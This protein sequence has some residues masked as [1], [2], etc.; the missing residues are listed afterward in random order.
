VWQAGMTLAA[1]TLKY[2]YCGALPFAG[3]SG[4][5]PWKSFKDS[6][7]KF[8]WVFEKES[9]M[10]RFKL[11]PHGALVVAAGALVAALAMYFWMKHEQ[12]ATAQELPFAARIQ[13]VDGEVAFSDNRT[14]A[15]ANQ[16]WTAATANQP[17]SEGDRIYTRDN[18][19][20]S[21]AFNGRNFARL[22]PNTSLDCL[23]LRDRRTQLALRDG[24][25]MFDV[26]YLQPDEIFEVAT[27]NGSVNFVQPGLYNVGFDQNGGV[28]VSVLS[29]LAQVA[30][31][32]GSGQVNKGEMLTLLGQ[33]ASQIALSRLNGQDAGRQVDDYYRYQYPN[34]YD[35]RY[36]NYDAYLN[37][38]N[39]YDPSRR[40]VSYQYASSYIPGLNDLDSYGDW[41]NVSGYGNVWR[42][43][44]SNGWVPYQDGQWVNNYPYGPTWVSN[45][46]W[47]YAPY[48]YGRWANVGNQWY[49]IPDSAN[50]TPQ[51]APALVAFV[52]LND[53]N[54]IGWVPLGPGDNY[55]P[56]YYDENWQPR[57]LQGNVA[58]ARLVNLG[59]PGAVTVVP[60]DAFGRAIDPRNVRRID[61]ARLASTS[62]TLDPLTYTPLRNAFVNSAPSAF[63]RGKINL[64]PGI[65]KKLNDTRVY[66]G[67]DITDSRFRKDFAR[68]MRVER[69]SDQARNQKFKVKDER[70]E[71]QADNGRRQDL[72]QDLG[73]VSAE[74]VKD[75]KAGKENKDVQRQ[76]RQLEQQQQKDVRVAERA[77]AQ[78][79]RQTR[80]V[81]QQQ[82]RQARV[83][84]RAQAQTQRHAQQEQKRQAAPAERARVQAQPAQVQ[85]QRQSQPR[86]EQRPQPQRPEAQRVAQPARPA[87]S[88]ARP[89][90]QAAPKQERKQKPLDAKPGG[91]GNGGG[92][93]KGKG[94]KP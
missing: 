1:L 27:P 88:E 31:L 46:S 92:G 12:T 52:P 63:G 41:Q 84:E 57:Y 24:S 86:M 5:R 43:R 48:H 15:Q 29:G 72:R 17:F 87:R 68:S 49:W 3:L 73:R 81:E 45:E 14:G 16:D 22:N 66:A 67:N 93:G 47:G 59:I 55:A 51:Y 70:G 25:A 64:P 36:N 37:E 40:N 54:Q 79:Q 60:V 76:T 58:P 18:A 61:Q 56:R 65:A 6:P 38:P 9:F 71:A 44:V 7:E 74:A 83:S 69:V 53:T 50:T 28:L 75:N 42:P 23:S 62:A 20:T 11:W 2:Q 34:S 30:G 13:R 8:S 89:A 90:P 80:Q 78:T 39:Y 32:G 19:R 26:G 33:A 82:T 91:E 94:K 4:F 35:G 10:N 85:S 77:Q 21:L